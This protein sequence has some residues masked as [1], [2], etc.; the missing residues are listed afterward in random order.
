MCYAGNTI[1]RTAMMSFLSELDWRIPALVLFSGIQLFFTIR[2][3]FV[4]PRKNPAN[5]ITKGESVN[6]VTLNV[7]KGS[8]VTVSSSPFSTKVEM[9]CRLTGKF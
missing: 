6:T 3:T 4:C 2:K 9:Y 7:F 5:V 1:T 8:G